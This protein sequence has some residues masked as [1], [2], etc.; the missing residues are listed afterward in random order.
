[1][2]NPN[3]ALSAP[4]TKIEQCGDQTLNCAPGSISRLGK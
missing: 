4:A 1:M 2:D 3:V